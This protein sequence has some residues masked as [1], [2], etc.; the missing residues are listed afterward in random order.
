MGIQTPPPFPSPL[1]DHRKQYTILTII[2][3]LTLINQPL[4]FGV[5]VSIIIFLGLSFNCI[6]LKLYKATGMQLGYLDYKI[7][8]I[9]CD[10]ILRPRTNILFLFL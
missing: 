8:Y 1:V 4:I 10:N 6:K 5:T 9:Q 2:H 3:E 7:S